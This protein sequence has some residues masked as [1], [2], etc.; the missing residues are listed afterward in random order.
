MAPPDTPLP[1]TTEVTGTALDAMTTSNSAIAVPIPAASSAGAA[2]APGVSTSV[3]TGQP[4]R[5]A[6]TLRYDLAGV[7]HDHLVADPPDPGS[8]F[9][10]GRHRLH[11]RH[12]CRARLAVTA[13]GGGHW[14][15]LTAPGVDTSPYP[16]AGPCPGGALPP[17][18]PRV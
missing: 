15:F 12:P 6:R 17:P 3:R 7:H 14:H 16:V 13:D 9:G 10:S 4:N 5:S 18:P 8:R 1:M 11:G 2:A